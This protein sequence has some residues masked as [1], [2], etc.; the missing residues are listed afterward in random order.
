[1]TQIQLCCEGGTRIHNEA[2]G[3]QIWRIS[4]SAFS[5]DYL[6]LSL[7]LSDLSDNL[8]IFQDNLYQIRSE[9]P[10][11]RPLL[12]FASEN[13]GAILYRK[14]L[15]FALLSTIGRIN[16]RQVRARKTLVELDV[17]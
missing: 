12:I 5:P 7:S 8:I 10:A 17:L 11:A 2:T 15:V 13:G 4:Y 3:C 6:A 16:Q 9:G 14:Y 1:M